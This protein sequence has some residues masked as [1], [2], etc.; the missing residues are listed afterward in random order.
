[1][2]DDDLAIHINPKADS[3]FTAVFLLE[4][5][6]VFVVLLSKAGH[7]ACPLGPATAAMALLV[8]CVG[9]L[10]VVQRF[11]PGTTHPSARPLTAVPGLPPWAGGAAARSAIAQRDGLYAYTDAGTR[12]QNEQFVVLAAKL[13]AAMFQV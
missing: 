11:V 13:R 12:E 4:I 9:T 1:M 3:A 2:S 8:S 10:A 7:V 5:A 6:A